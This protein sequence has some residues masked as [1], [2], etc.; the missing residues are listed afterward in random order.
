[1]TTPFRVADSIKAT[2]IVRGFTYSR[3][4]NQKMKNALVGVVEQ[5][6]RDRKIQ[7]LLKTANANLHCSIQ[8]YPTQCSRVLWCPKDV[9]YLGQ[10]R[11][12]SK[13]TSDWAPDI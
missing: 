7:V 3:K 9:A 6:Y 5:I 13:R 4:S 2:Q 11:H 8:R 12:L 1:M 10:V